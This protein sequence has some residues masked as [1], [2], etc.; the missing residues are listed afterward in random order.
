MVST[1]HCQV[2]KA[3]IKPEQSETR[4]QTLSHN[5]HTY[6]EKSPEYIPNITSRALWMVGV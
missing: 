4:S 2:N 6:A 5:V 1:A 3:R